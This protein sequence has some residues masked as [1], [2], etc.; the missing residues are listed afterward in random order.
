[1]P[2]VTIVLGS[3][4]DLKTVE[5]S[6]MTDVLDEVKIS[7]EVSIIS[8]HRNSED[9]AN[10]CYEN[11]QTTKVFIGVAGMAAALPGAIAANLLNWNPIIIG[12]PLV[13]DVLDGMDSLLSMVR[14]PPGIPLAVTGIGKSGLQN[15]S[16]LASKIVAQSEIQ[17]SKDLKTYLSSKNKKAE[18][19]IESSERVE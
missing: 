3:R 10:Y 8:A 13:S 6:K 16:I 18:I 14:M 4:S 17:V 9:L 5:E 1:M 11:R 12:V 19:A 2:K 7:W 15:A